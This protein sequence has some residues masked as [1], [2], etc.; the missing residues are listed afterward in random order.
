M[1]IGFKEKVTP[2]SLVLNNRYHHGDWLYP[3]P[4]LIGCMDVLIS[5]LDRKRPLRPLFRDLRRMKINN[6]TL[7]QPRE[8]NATGFVEL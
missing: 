4:T 7:H 5:W 2:W 3:Q 6:F 8:I 1:E